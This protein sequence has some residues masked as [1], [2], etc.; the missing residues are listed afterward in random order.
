MNPFPSIL[1]LQQGSKLVLLMATY[2]VLADSK[3]NRSLLMAL[4][5]YRMVFED[6]GCFSRLSG[7]HGSSPIYILR[8]TLKL[9]SW[10][11]FIHVEVCIFCVERW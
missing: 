3:H 8:R 7:H 10:K 5:K 9:G 11:S 4:T 2:L 6:M 1:L